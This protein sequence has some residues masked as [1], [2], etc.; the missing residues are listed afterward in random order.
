MF[1][2]GS[3]WIWEQMLATGKYK[4]LKFSGDVD[5]V[6]A[7]QG[8]LGWLDALTATGDVN[9]QVTEPW[10]TYFVG[11]QTGGWIEKRGKMTFATINGAGHMVPQDKPAT[12]HHLIFNW[13]NDQDI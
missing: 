4:M 1:A 5:G 6:V 9:W 7:T 13:I 8:T 2:N 11:D 10:R 12:A 3:Q